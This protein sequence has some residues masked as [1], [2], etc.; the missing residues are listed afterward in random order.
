MDKEEKRKNIL[1]LMGKNEWN[2]ARNLADW[3][4]ASEADPYLRMCRAMCAW[5]LSDYAF[6]AEEYRDLLSLDIASSLFHPVDIHR[7]TDRSL[8]FQNGKKARATIDFSKISND[9]RLIKVI[10]RLSYVFHHIQLPVGLYVAESEADYN[11]FFSEAFPGKDIYPYKDFCA[12]CFYHDSRKRWIV[13][14]REHIGSYDDM[15]LLGECAH[16]M[17][18]LDGEGLGFYDCDSFFFRGSFMINE[19]VTDWYAISRGFAYPLYL[20]RKKMGASDM[21]MDQNDL[22]EY[23]DELEK[24]AVNSR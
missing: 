2:G 7:M 16:E 20:V 17:A 8:E 9:D 12:T 22:K 5:E 24:F 6:A 19:K 11:A 14:K 13:F 4:L 15:Q 21:V 1:A 10:T 23:F 3:Y 18:H